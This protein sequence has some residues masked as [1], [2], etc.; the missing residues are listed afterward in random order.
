MKVVLRNEKDLGKSEKS[1]STAEDLIKPGYI[2]F[3]A[4][5]YKGEISR[6]KAHGKGWLY[7]PKAGYRV[8]GEW[9]HDSLRY[10]TVYDVAP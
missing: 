4:A 8:E 7:Y 5:Y 3:S 2:I 10:G 1:E 6:G 9:K